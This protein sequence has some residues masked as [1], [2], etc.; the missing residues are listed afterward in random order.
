MPVTKDEIAQRFMAFA[1]RYGFR[2]T[3]LE[4]VA[5]TLHISKKTLYAFFANK[6][7][8][9]RYAT[10][11]SASEQRRRVEA[12]LSAQSALEQSLQV[13]S[14]ALA[15]VRR[16]VE[17]GPPSDIWEPSEITE[18]VN[19]QVF[20]PMVRALIVAGVAQ[21]EFAV[22]D[23]DFTTACCMAVGMEAVRVIRQDPLR[24]PEAAALEA[25]RRLLAGEAGSR[26]RHLHEQ[27]AAST[28]ATPSRHAA[29][30]SPLTKRDA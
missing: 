28:G 18:Q 7:D 4:D 6:E 24:R 23:V 21:G 13:M 22:T 26:R 10:Q 30:E 17:S 9:L 27:D 20:A 12:Q 1:L 2:R 14:L 16:A 25:V 19:A 29:R 5:R 3:T 8:L 11:L 15:D